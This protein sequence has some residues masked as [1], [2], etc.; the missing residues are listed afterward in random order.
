MTLAKSYR[1]E[2]NAFHEEKK[3]KET[4]ITHPLEF[5]FLLMKC[6]SEREQ[7]LILKKNF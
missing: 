6:K 3:A 4:Y 1:T 5:F 2:K 7:Y